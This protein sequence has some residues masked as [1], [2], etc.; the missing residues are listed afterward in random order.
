MTSTPEVDVAPPT[1][2][3]P[4]LQ[5]TEV[6]QTDA[7]YAVFLVQSGRVALAVTHQ[8]VWA[9]GFHPGPNPEPDMQVSKSSGS[10]DCL[11]HWSAAAV[12]RTRSQS[13][14]DVL[15]YRCCYDRSHN[16]LW[17]TSTFIENPPD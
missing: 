12:G 11:D 5:V 13:I 9:G 15:C 6:I 4:P 17:T 3:D 2:Y 7:S 10:P 8:V 1:R 16:L 14:A